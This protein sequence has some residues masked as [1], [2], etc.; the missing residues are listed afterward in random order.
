MISRHLSRTTCL[1]LPTSLLFSLLL[2]ACSSKTTHEGDD[3]GVTAND[4]MSVDSPSPAPDRGADGPV[5]DAAP[6]DAATGD[7]TPDLALPGT[8]KMG[9]HCVEDE[10]CEGD[11]ICAEG[12]YTSAHCSPVCTDN[13]PCIDEAANVKGTCTPVGGFEGNICLF[14]CGFMADGADC[15]GDLICVGGAACR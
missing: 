14:F 9:E 7:L 6:A 2:M 5:N 8:K 3:L 13:T 4:A 12:E 11:A 1:F 15:P 10:E